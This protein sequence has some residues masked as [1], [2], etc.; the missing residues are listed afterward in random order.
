MCEGLGKSH[1]SVRILRFVRSAQNDDEINRAPRPRG[2]DGCLVH[3]QQLLTASA[4]DGGGR[5]LFVSARVRSPT[6]AK[7]CMFGK[8]SLLVSEAAFAT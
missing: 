6:T 2:A 4:D 5:G 1:I 7:E 8:Q 3:H